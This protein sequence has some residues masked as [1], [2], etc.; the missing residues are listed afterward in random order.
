[1]ALRVD[2]HE[3]SNKNGMSAE[4]AEGGY[5]EGMSKR[6]KEPQQANV[7]AGMYRTASTV[8]LRTG[9]AFRLYRRNVGAVNRQNGRP[10]LLA[11]HR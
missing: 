1:M 9:A 3:I 11:T 5:S 7:E 8:R 4:G 6:D 2:N 10:Y